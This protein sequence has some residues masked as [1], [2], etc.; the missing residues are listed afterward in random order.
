MEDFLSLRDRKIEKEQKMSSSRVARKYT[1]RLYVFR[2]YSTWLSV[3][4]LDIN[5]TEYIWLSTSNFS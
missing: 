2:E 1:I 5:H 3:I 4:V